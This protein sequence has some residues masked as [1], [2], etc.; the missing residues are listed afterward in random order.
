MRISDWS[1]DV[2]SSDLPRNGQDACAPSR[3]PVR[4][5]M[6]PRKPSRMATSRPA[7]PIPT[8]KTGR[9]EPHEVQA[10]PPALWPD[11]RAGDALSASGPDLV[12]GHRLKARPG[13]QLDAAA[14]L[15][16]DAQRRSEEH[17][18]ELQSLISIS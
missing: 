13:A 18:S 1:S 5:A 9:T 4:T 15:L 3:P 8:S 14:V 10:D 6:P 11:T 12:R 2:C 16:P 17:Q 7:L